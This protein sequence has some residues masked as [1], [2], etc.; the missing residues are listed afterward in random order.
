MRRNCRRP[1]L[2]HRRVQASGSL[3]IQPQFQYKDS[4]PALP[5]PTNFTPKLYAFFYNKALC[6]KGN[7]VSNTYN[8]HTAMKR[9]A[10]Y[11]QENFNPNKNEYNPNE[12]IIYTWLWNIIF[13]S[14]ELPNHI[15]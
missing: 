3:L 14:E 12:F 1:C 2:T 5:V 13:F 4:P 6:F 8:A 15:F 7:N 9:N 10:C 11:I